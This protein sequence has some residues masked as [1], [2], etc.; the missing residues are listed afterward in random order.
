MGFDWD[1]SAA[2]GII[3]WGDSSSLS[4]GGG[5][6]N[7][8]KSSASSVFDWVGDSANDLGTWAKENQGGALIIG[9]T[10][11]AA[12]QYITQ[13][14]ADKAASRRERDQFNRESARYDE[15]HRVDPLNFEV[16]T[17]AGSVNGNAPLTYGGLLTQMQQNQDEYQKKLKGV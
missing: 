4:S 5:L 2:S 15:L 12:G 17:D 3:G 9:S 7:S 16:S 6:W 14:Q 10:I 13:K 8:I 1:S 11:G